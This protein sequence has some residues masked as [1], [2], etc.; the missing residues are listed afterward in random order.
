MQ[1]RFVANF[2]LRGD[3]APCANRLVQR[4]LCDEPLEC[5]G[6][7]AQWGQGATCAFASARS[8]NS[9][10]SFGIAIVTN[11]DVQVSGACSATVLRSRATNS[12]QKQSNWE[13]DAQQFI[14]ILLRWKTISCDWVEVVRPPLG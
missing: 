9:I 3:E 12:A 13:K 2:D 4:Y 7:I 11:V 8:D 14:H 1:L 10:E 5:D 6:T